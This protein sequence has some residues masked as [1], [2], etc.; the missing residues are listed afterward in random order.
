MGRIFTHMTMSLDGFI[1][2]PDDGVGELFGWYEAGPVTVPSADERWS[3]Q[4]DE[5]SA[6]MLRGVM[7][8]TGALVCG[9]RL[10]EHTRGWGDRHPIGASVVV[11]THQA[12]EDAGRWQTI[13][14][15]DGVKQGLDLVDEVII[16]LAPVMLGKGIAYFGD[17]A[18]P[19]HRFGDPVI[20][21]GHRVTHLRYPVLRAGR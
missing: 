1:A 21:A 8:T 19:P 11:V 12:P 9:R 3:F 10:F 17:L 14:F 13:S 6:R 18:H 4:V 7:S 2:D 5:D 20:I 15:A 16:S